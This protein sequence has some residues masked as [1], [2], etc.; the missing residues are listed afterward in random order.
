M[1][2]TITDRLVDQ[3]HDLSWEVA[4]LRDKVK[5]LEEA[6]TRALG[7]SYFKDARDHLEKELFREESQ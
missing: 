3:V 1:T 4:L 2:D 7:S 6:C 5:R